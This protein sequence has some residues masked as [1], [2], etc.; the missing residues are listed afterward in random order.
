MMR[1]ARHPATIAW[2]ALMAATCISGW[3]AETERGIH[4][5]TVAIL[6]IASVKIGLIMHE[7]MEL[8]TAPLP[9]RLAMG[10]WLLTVTGIVLTAA[11]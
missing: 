6:L 8:K 7:F 3:L 5:A 4:W 1:L 11:F 9:W 10:T 2:V